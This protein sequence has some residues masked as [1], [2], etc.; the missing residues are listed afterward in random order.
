MAEFDSAT[1]GLNGN[2]RPATLTTF[3]SI[4]TGGDALNG[5]ATVQGTQW[6]TLTKRHWQSKILIPLSAAAAAQVEEEGKMLTIG[7]DPEV[8]DADAAEANGCAVVA[9][10]GGTSGKTSG[11]LAAIAL[12]AASAVVRRRKRA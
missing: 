8:S 1:R 5:D 2:L 12:V 3:L 6:K 11:I 9:R 7:F 4:G 10:R